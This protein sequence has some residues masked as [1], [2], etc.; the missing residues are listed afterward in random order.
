MSIQLNNVSKTYHLKGRN[1]EALKP[2]SLKVETGEIFGLI[3]YSGAGKSTLVRLINLLEKPSTGTVIVGDDNLTELSSKDLR[4][5]RQ[6]IGMIF[7][8]F[9]L[10]ESK[11]VYENIEF[12]LKASRYNKKMC[13]KELKSF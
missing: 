2:T 8:Q 7:Q 4:I 6:K 11:T 10:I 5:R 9:N 3:G 1:V 13:R 12:V